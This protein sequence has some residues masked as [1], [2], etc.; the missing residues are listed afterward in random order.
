MRQSV[1]FLVVAF[2]LGCGKSSTTPDTAGGQ[3]PGSDEQLAQGTWKVV[4]VE[5]PPGDPEP[6][7]DQLSAI[8]LT[9]KSNLVTVSG[10]GKPDQHFTFKLDPTRS[11]KQVD[12]LEAD[13]G[14]NPRPDGEAFLGIYKQEGDNLVIASAVD[15][16]PKGYRPTE[17]KAALTK[18]APGQQHY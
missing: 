15:S 9:V 7:P 12:F 4:K 2:A 6:R 14:G 10:P 18:P 5:L 11:P 16:N 8:G 13:A 3:P 1:V 17:F